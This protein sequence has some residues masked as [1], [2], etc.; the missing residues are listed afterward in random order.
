MRSHPP[1][2]STPIKPDFP[3]LTIVVRGLHLPHLPAWSYPLI[4][5]KACD[6]E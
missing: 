1:V 3:Q 2:I 6:S 4:Q 5:K